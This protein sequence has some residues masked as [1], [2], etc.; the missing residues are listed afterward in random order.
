VNR[1]IPIALVF[2]MLASGCYSTHIPAEFKASPRRS[3]YGLSCTDPYALTNGCGP[4]WLTT[5]PLEI[6]GVQFL[7][8]STADGH[9]IL[10]GDS[11]GHAVASSLPSFITLGAADPEA[12]RLK[13][14]LEVVR[15]CLAAAA[16]NILE[17]T[18]VTNFGEVDG[19]LV[20]TDG[21][22]MTALRAAANSS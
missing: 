10:M 5:I 17:V 18:V 4:A 19:Y 7:T 8:S 11:F 20:V 2:A 6:Q 13:K 16:I 14:A 21:D 3:I 9:V 1:F 22:A 12:E 15:Q